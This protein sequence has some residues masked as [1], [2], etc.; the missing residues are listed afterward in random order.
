MRIPGCGEAAFIASDICQRGCGR[1]NCKN[2]NGQGRGGQGV[3]F[4]AARSCEGSDPDIIGSGS[5]VLYGGGGNITA[6]NH[7]CLAGSEAAVGCI[8]HRIAVHILPGVP[9]SREA[10]FAAGDLRQRGCVRLGRSNRNRHSSGSQRVGFAAARSLKGSDPDVIASGIQAVYGCR[11]SAAAMDNHCHAGGKAAVGCI[12]QRISIHILLDVPVCGKAAFIAGDLRQRGCVRSERTNRNSQGRGSQRVG[13]IAVNSLKGSDPDIVGSGSQILYGGGGNITAINHHCLAG[14]ETAV[15]CILHRIAV[16]ILPGIPGGREAAIAAG[17]LC[18]CGYGRLDTNCFCFNRR[19]HFAQGILV[20][21]AAD[22]ANPILVIAVLRAGGSLCGNLN[23][24][25]DMVVVVNGGIEKRFIYT[26]DGN[27]RPLFFASGKEDVSK[28]VAPS[29]GSAANAGDSCGDGYA[30]ETAAPTEG[31]AVNAGDSLRDG[32]AGEATALSEG[33]E[34]N[35]GYF[36]GD[37]YTDKVAAPPEGTFANTG[38]LRIQNDSNNL[39]L[40]FI[41]RYIVSGPSSIVV[42]ITRTGNGQRSVLRQRPRQVFAAGAGSNGG[43]V[44][45]CIEKRFI[46]LC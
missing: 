6:I 8:L 32:Y 37:G 30:G 33:T 45:G 4:A 36:I 21:L 9:G 42:H 22:G 35:A 34:A 16:H 38:N 2:C 27:R 23:Q 25:A 19:L 18:Q 39:L 26:S 43:V 1:L 14:S 28:A 13:F 40:I 11:G 17:D 12:L 29:E 7:H 31:S 24:S 44:N 15:G 5:Q 41:P 46:S 3:G 10:A 20:C